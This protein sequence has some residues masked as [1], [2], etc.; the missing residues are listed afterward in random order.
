MVACSGIGSPATSREITIPSF[1]RLAARNYNVLFCSPLALLLR[2]IGR[3]A[4]IFLD[5]VPKLRWYIGIT[6]RERGE[7]EGVGCNHFV[8]TEDHTEFLGREKMGCDR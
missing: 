3:L 8:T 4:V 1:F 7:R 6:E 2:G 5:S